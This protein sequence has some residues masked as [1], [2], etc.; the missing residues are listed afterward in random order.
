MINILLQ[1]DIL[2]LKTFLK[3]KKTN[4][5]S[6]IKNKTLY[7]HLI[8]VGEILETWEL[9]RDTIV[10]GYCHSIYS[11]EVF[12]E[13]LN[14]Q[15]EEL[16]S[17]IGQRAERLVYY[18]SILDR[19]S[20]KNEDGKYSF[21]NYKNNEVINVNKNDFVSILH[22][23]ISNEIDHVTPIN[24]GFVRSLLGKYVKYSDLLCIRA[25]NY[26]EKYAKDVS[27]QSVLKEINNDKDVDVVRFIAHAGI[28]FV[29]SGVS[30]A[31]D[32]WI[33]S[34]ELDY[35]VVQGFPG[36]KTIDFIIP[37]PKNTVSDISPDVVLL[38]H[39]HTHHSPLREFVEFAK[40]K[41]I[42]LICPSMTDWAFES[43][44]KSLDENVFNNIKFEFVEKDR[45][46]DF[47]GVKV[48]AMTQTQIGHIVFLIEG[49]NSSVL[50][51]VDAAVN[52]D[53]NNI[54]FSKTWDKL[55]NVSP[56]FLFVGAAGHARRFIVDGKRYINENET[57]SPVQASKFAGLVNAVNVAP[58]GIYNHSIGNG[59]VEYVTPPGLVEHEF[60]WALSFLFSNIKFRTLKPG[61]TF[62][63]KNKKEVLN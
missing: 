25:K 27:N 45:E 5:I 20:L 40:N 49:I 29:S 61:D 59:R 10:A 39:F 12:K 32:P 9:D 21:S 8:R 6:H 4:S 46:F 35:P 1:K 57:F 38:S 54:S 16:I 42:T 2:K 14:I 56:D 24:Y 63:F 47:N 7:D 53:I 55:L 50:H 22:I 30:F 33:Y 58:I 23:L 37:E 18:F 51:V 19:S 34:S 28:N 3:L 36:S 11:T 43:L 17:V 52:E 31:V 26:L 15:K 41:K 13:D 62:Y 44:Q 60:Y 48:K